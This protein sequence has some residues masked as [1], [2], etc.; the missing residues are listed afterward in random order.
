MVH[1]CWGGGKEVQLLL[2]EAVGLMWPWRLE[3]WH[4]QISTAPPVWWKS[5]WCHLS[6][7]Q[8]SSFQ[9]KVSDVPSVGCFGWKWVIWQQLLSL[10]CWQNTQS[11][12][13]IWWRRREGN[14][15]VRRPVRL[16]EDQCG[17]RPVYRD[18]VQS[19]L[20]CL[21]RHSTANGRVRTDESSCFCLQVGHRHIVDATLQEKACSVASLIMSVTHK[22]MVTC[23]RK[24]GGGSLDPESIFEMTEVNP[25]AGQLRVVSL[26]ILLRSRMSRTFNGVLA[27]K[28]PKRKPNQPWWIKFILK[29]CG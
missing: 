17:E 4:K 14:R 10:F 26:W 24:V 25:A 21:A 3:V 29:K 16:H 12:H 22:G 2:T 8:G 19:E 27:N 20:G 7:Y 13:I 5:L 28:K 15:A 18:P 11:F 9:H 6:S 1:F 23:T